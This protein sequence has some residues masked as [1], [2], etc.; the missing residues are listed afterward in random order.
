MVGLGISVPIGISGIVL[1]FSSANLFSSSKT[2]AE[3]K[4]IG[5]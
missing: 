5:P 1:L 2:V 4:A 3:V